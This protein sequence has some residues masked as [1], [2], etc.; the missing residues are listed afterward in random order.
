MMTKEEMKD[1]MAADQ[2]RSFQA[3]LEKSETKLLMSMIP[4]ANTPELLP[5]LLRSAFDAGNSSG[6]GAVLGEMLTAMLSKPPGDR[7]D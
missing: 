3:W 6:Q 2:G 4:P 1:R 5:T 7:R